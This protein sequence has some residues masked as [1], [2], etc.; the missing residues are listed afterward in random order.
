MFRRRQRISAADLP[1]LA[2][3]DPMFTAM[4]DLAGVRVWQGV[5]LF[6]LE[7]VA[8]GVAVRDAG[9]LVCP[10]SEGVLL[11]LPNASL[12]RVPFSEM[13]DLRRGHASGWNTIEWTGKTPS[14]QWVPIRLGTTNKT[15]AT[16]LLDKLDELRLA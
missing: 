13:H 15:K 10:T 1:E 16:A 9:V 2:P 14:D 6:D 4:P 5:E 3:D 8:N 12:R 11:V 7:R